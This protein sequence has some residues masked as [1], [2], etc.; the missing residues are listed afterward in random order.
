MTSRTEIVG[1]RVAMQ[2]IFYKYA[3]EY[4]GPIHGMIVQTWDYMNGVFN[5][6]CAGMASSEDFQV[7]LRLASTSIYLADE[8]PSEDELAVWNNMWDEVLR[9]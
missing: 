6:L 3:W 7:Y 1:K 5:M 4:E 9:L 2:N 8:F